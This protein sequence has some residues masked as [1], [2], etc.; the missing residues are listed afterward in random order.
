LIYSQP[1]T[2]S[3]PI[4]NKVL[5]SKRLG[6]SRTPIREAFYKL[7]AEGFLTIKPRQGAKANS[8]T[9]LTGAILLTEKTIPPSAV[10]RKEV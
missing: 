4:T 2:T 10:Y 7:E 6:I 1:E 5:T 8:P 9:N 3:E